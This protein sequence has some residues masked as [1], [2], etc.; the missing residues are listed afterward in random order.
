MSTPF[1]LLFGVWQFCE[2]FSWPGLTYAGFH[3]IFTLPA[4]ALSMCLA[5]QT[6]RDVSPTY[7]KVACAVTAV[8]CAVATI[9]TSPW[10]NYLVKLGVWDYPEVGHVIGVLGYVP[11]E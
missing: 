3:G 6:A 2:H 9:W 5:R 8:L 10:D 4:L 7:F 1:C 11:I